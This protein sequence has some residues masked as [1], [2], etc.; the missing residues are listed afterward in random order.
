MTE[1]IF[2]ITVMLFYYTQRRITNQNDASWA[3]A[4][5]TKRFEDATRCRF[6]QDLPTAMFD[7]FIMFLSKYGLL[8]RCSSFP[9]YSWT[10]WTAQMGWKGC[11]DMD[12]PFHHVDEDTNYW[13]QKK[14]W[15]VWYRRSP[16]GITNLVW[17]S[18]ANPSFPIKDMEYKGIGPEV[19]LQ[20]AEMFPCRFIQGGFYL[21]SKFPFLEMCHLTLYCSFGRSPWCTTPLVL[22]ALQATVTLEI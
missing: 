2:D 1:P 6:F 12:S 5:I 16:S 19:P 21:L 3:T 4:G 15:I 13:L 17:D 18:A 14:T 10:G 20:M 9:S 7:G 8:H 22:V 11:G